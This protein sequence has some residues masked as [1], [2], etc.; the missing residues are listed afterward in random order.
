MNYK[1]LVTRSDGRMY[2]LYSGVAVAKKDNILVLKR[3]FQR[4]YKSVYFVHGLI[5]LK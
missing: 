4:S 3:T 2:F 1:I 5:Y